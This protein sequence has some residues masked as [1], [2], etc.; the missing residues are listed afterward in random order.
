MPTLLGVSSHRKC[1]DECVP[2]RDVAWVIDR[3]TLASIGLIRSAKRN[4]MALV[5]PARNVLAF[6]MRKGP[7]F[8]EGWAHACG[9]RSKMRERTAFRRAI[10][11][12]RE[13]W[14]SA[15]EFDPA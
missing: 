5:P 3:G 7:R 6:Q 10:R 8:G 11:G 1:K 2:N 14:C 15:A 12:P 9:I 13:D 4:R